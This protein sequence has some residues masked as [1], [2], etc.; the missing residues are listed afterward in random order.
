MI[1][2][3]FVN[4]EIDE[5]EV[6]QCARSSMATIMAWYGSHYAGDDYLV[7]AHGKLE[8]TDFNGE[9]IPAQIEL[10]ANQSIKGA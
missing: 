5:P 3:E 4:S 1:S 9:P 2:L 8:P 7:F 6:V 10:T